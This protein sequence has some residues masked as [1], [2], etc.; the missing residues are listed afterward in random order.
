MFI[1]LSESFLSQGFVLTQQVMPDMKTVHLNG[2]DYRIAEDQLITVTAACLEKG[3]ALLQVNGILNV[4]LF[5]DRCL[6]PVK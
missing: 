2:Q 3:K 6:A 1:N 4:E 5:C